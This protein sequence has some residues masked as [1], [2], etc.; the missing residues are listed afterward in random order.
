LA[1][2]IVFKKV[3]SCFN[4]LKSNDTSSSRTKTSSNKSP[5]ERSSR[6]PN[7]QN[8]ESTS[9]ISKSLHEQKNESGKINEDI[10]LSNDSFGSSFDP[11]NFN[12]NYFDA[13]NKTIKANKGTTESILL[14]EN[15]DIKVTKRQQVNG[16]LKQPLSPPLLTTQLRMKESDFRAKYLKIFENL[17]PT[18]CRSANKIGSDPQDSP[19]HQKT[20]LHD[21][22]NSY[23]PSQSTTE[24]L[25]SFAA[26][27]ELALKRED[28]FVEVIP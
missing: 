7:K 22:A 3:K 14:F 10:Y 18:R 28:S 25:E 23:V 21:I 19:G 9:P 15:K 13:K 5:Q 17:S 2:S 27:S 16:T 6:S 24:L 8:D 26:A 11:Q 20:S 1:R 12:F 4:H